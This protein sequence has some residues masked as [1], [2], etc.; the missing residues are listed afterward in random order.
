MKKKICF[1]LPSLWGH[2]GAERVAYNLLNN[3]SLDKFDLHLILTKEKGDAF[4]KLRSE[5][6]YSILNCRK[7]R[8]SIIKIYK[9]LKKIK[10]DIVIIFSFEISML[11]GVFISPFLKNIKFINRQLNLISKSNFSCLRKIFLKIAYGNFNKIISQ[12]KDMTEDL[13]KNIKISKEKIIEINNPV[14]F[15]EIKELSEKKMEIE[16]NSKNKNLLCVGRLSRQKGFDKIIEIMK[17]F[18]GTNIKLY[19]LGIGKERKNLDNMIEKYDLEGTVFL[20]GRKRNPYIY[21]K[22][23]DLFIL[24]SRYEG[25]PNSLLEAGVCGLYSI[26]N[27]SPGGIN[28]IIEEGINGNIIDFNNK[29]EVKNIIL[30]NLYEDKNKDKIRNIV[31]DR[32]NLEKIIGKYSKLLENI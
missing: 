23:A 32:Y 31:L 17:L 2:G 9:K 20:L 27:D 28:E 6:K 3:L 4:K 14:N 18:K 21:M 12:S 11:V 24:S 15:K 29:L 26:C 22:N 13:M 1:I 16:F 8:Y 30:K 10:P 7:S 25:F 5:V 19:I